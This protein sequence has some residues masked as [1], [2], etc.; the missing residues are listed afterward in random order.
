MR[1]EVEAPRA[2]RCVK[3]R[4]IGVGRGDRRAA[5]SVVMS[6]GD[7]ADDASDEQSLD[8]LSDGKAD[9][10]DD[11]DESDN[12][13]GGDAV[14][15]AD[16]EDDVD[17]LMSDRKSS[18]YSSS[19]GMS[20]TTSPRKIASPTLRRVCETVFLLCVL[21]FF[22]MFFLFEIKLGN[23]II[24]MCCIRHHCRHASCRCHRCSARPW[25]RLPR[26]I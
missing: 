9:D 24:K 14:A 20:P 5:S 13:D 12:E 17:K 18:T 22:C 4:L 26:A 6:S 10:D 3:L 1:A 23:R 11:V 21:F 25:P 16:D 2:V 15:N 8:T 19:S 7:K